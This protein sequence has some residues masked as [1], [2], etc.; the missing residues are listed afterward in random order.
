MF[1]YNDKNIELYNGFIGQMIPGQIIREEIYGIAKST[2]YAMYRIH[3]FTK[4]YNYE[5]LREK[6]INKEINEQ[7]EEKEGEF[8]TEIN[9]ELEE[10]KD[11]VNFDISEMNENK[12]IYYLYN[13]E[14]SNYI[15][16][17]KIKDKN[18]VKNT[19]VRF[20]LTNTKN[21]STNIR[22][23]IVYA[24]KTSHIIKL[25]SFF[26]K[27]I[28]DHAKENDIN[29]FLNIYRFRDDLDF[30]KNDDVLCSLKVK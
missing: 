19:L 24:K 20:V 25:N 28:I 5:E 21:T 18:K 8:N 11:T 6:L 1:K 13:E 4:Y 16:E 2:A 27:E 15:I 9:S 30:L 22:A 3:Y 10:L 26:P 7:L 29:N 12:I 14:I 23:N 17:D